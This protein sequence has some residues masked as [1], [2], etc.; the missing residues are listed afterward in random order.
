MIYRALGLGFR[1]R[2]QVFHGFWEFL[3]VLERFYHVLYTCFYKSS[4]RGRVFSGAGFRKHRVQGF[5]LGFQVL[6][7]CHLAK[8]G[9]KPST[10]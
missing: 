1:F 10:L 5:H 4:I 7:V 2:V 6:Q 3:G 8:P 9:P